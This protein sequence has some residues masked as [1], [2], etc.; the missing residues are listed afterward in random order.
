MERLRRSALDNLLQRSGHPLHQPGGSLRSGD[1]LLDVLMTV[2]PQKSDPSNQQLQ[3]ATSGDRSAETF[4]VPHEKAQP[5]HILEV[6]HEKIDP[7]PPAPKLARLDEVFFGRQQLIEFCGEQ[8]HF[9]HHQHEPF[10]SGEHEG[11]NELSPLDEQQL[12]D[13]TQLIANES[14]F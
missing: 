5:A 2:P 6:P 7:F 14:G 9:P 10:R 11:G 8:Q 1:R 13:I 12:D 3:I 4:A